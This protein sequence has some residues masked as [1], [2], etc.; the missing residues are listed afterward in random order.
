M[1]PSPYTPGEVAR[2]VP[3]RFQQLA[4]FDERL[5]SLV[6]LRR[7]VGRIRVDHAPRGFGKTSLL[8]E[9]QRRA[10]ERG[11]LTVWVTAGESGGLIPQIAAEISRATAGWR[12][13]ARKAVGNMTAQASPWGTRQCTPRAALRFRSSVLPG[14]SSEAA[15]CWT[16]YDDFASNSFSLVCALLWRE[17]C[18]EGNDIITE[19]YVH[20][21]YTNSTR[22]GIVRIEMQAVRVGVTSRRTPSLNT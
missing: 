1:Q 2:T 6:D 12:E 5:S 15:R 19:R 16:G 21:A 9:Y 3:G 8:R 17:R 18:V 13:E 22:I 14:G 10:Q 4:D 7:L 20:R 11:A